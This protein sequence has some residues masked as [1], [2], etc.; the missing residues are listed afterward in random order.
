MTRFNAENGGLL[1]EKVSFKM[2]PARK[3]LLED[4][5]RKE[6]VTVSFVV[7]HLVYRFLEG[8]K[9]IMPQIGGM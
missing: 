9:R 4:Y 8:Q 1:L 7:R 5:A 6:G 3:Q 2:D